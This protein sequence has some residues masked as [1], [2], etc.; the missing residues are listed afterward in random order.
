VSLRRQREAA[1]RWEENVKVA[2]RRHELSRV[3]GEAR[4]NGATMRTSTSAA[5]PHERPTLIN[6]PLQR[7]ALTP[8]KGLNRFSG[9]HDARRVAETWETAEAV[10]VSPSSRPTPPKRGVNERA[11]NRTGPP[12]PFG[13]GHHRIHDGHCSCTDR[14]G[15]NEPPQAARQ[16]QD[17]LRL[18]Q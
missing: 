10:Q 16:A 5:Q 14:G 12:R 11:A 1:L 13:I 2:V 9:F 4:R 3:G 15:Q 18:C 7:G 6:T 8:S 17:V